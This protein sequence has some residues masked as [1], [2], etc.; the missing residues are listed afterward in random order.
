MSSGETTDIDGMGSSVS[1][2]NHSA[3][4]TPVTCR[5]TVLAVVLCALLAAPIAAQENGDAG[6]APAGAPPADGAPA[7]AAAADPL[8][9]D[10]LDPPAW[11]R[12]TAIYDTPDP[13]SLNGYDALHA[14]A[15]LKRERL[16]IRRTGSSRE[17]VPV[18]SVEAREVEPIEEMPPLHRRR[19]T[20]IL[21]EEPIEWERMYIDYGGRLLNL[22]LLFTYRNQRPVPD[23][24]FVL[25]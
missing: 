11:P 24:P 3:E 9:P 4:R 19:Y 15:L 12:S 17:I 7:D 25:E 23:A 1:P 13:F 14:I 10:A 16:L 18:R 8:P 5:I 6:G 22:Q 2:P 21:N 20:L